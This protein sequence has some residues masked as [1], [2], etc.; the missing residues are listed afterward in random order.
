MLSLFH[1]PVIPLYGCNEKDINQLSQPGKAW[2]CNSMFGL[3]SM[4]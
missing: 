3:E 1:L 2:N 4:V